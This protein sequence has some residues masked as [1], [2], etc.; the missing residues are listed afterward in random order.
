MTQHRPPLGHTPE[1]SISSQRKA[2]NPA[3]HVPLHLSSGGMLLGGVGRGGMGCGVKGAGVGAGAVVVVVEK[4]VVG[5]RV[6]GP[7]AP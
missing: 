1:R 2:K 5:V 7:P 4:V 6:T 3:T